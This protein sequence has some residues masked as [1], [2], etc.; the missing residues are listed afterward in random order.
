MKPQK[1]RAESGDFFHRLFVLQIAVA[2]FYN[3]GLRRQNNCQVKFYKPCFEAQQPNEVKFPPS[4]RWKFDEQFK[5]TIC[6]KL[7]ILNQF[8]Y[9]KM[10]PIWHHWAKNRAKGNFG[11]ATNKSWLSL[12]SFFSN[13]D[14]SAFKIYTWVWWQD[15]KCQFW[16]D[17]ETHTTNTDFGLSIN[18]NLKA[19]YTAEVTISAQ[20]HS[21]FKAHHN[22]R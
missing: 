7:P 3:F 4:T 22:R 1:L 17:F 16:I 2:Q 19:F 5:A 14:S 10:E 13:C 20:S 12:T 18:Q 15:L 8:Y 11:W 21:A 6:Q 9:Y